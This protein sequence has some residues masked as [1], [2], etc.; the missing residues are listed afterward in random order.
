MDRMEYVLL[1]GRLRKML[2]MPFTDPITHDLIEMRVRKMQHD[3]PRVRG[4]HLSRPARRRIDKA[5]RAM[6]ATLA[7]LGADRR[8]DDGGSR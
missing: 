1:D 8:G 3:A 7:A 2:A 4:R 5:L 6:E